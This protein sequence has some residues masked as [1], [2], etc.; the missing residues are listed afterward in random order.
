MG[1]GASVETRVSAAGA[2]RPTG[3]AGGRRQE[4][5][6]GASAGL[7]AVKTGSVCSANCS[8]RLGPGA[9][10][11]ALRKPGTRVSRSGVETLQGGDVVRKLAR[12]GGERGALATF[13]K[14]EGGRKERRRQ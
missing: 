11:W 3:S 10:L 8:T 12:E 6:A 9:M 2:V 13:R 1:G 7:T 4:E 14:R 5:A